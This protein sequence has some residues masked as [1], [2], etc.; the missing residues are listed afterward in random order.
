MRIFSIVHLRSK[1][2]VSPARRSKLGR[3]N[4]TAN[5]IGSFRLCGSRR[6]TSATATRSSLQ[7]RTALDAA[8][9]KMPVNTMGAGWGQQ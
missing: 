8:Y 3:G 6:L 9:A 4:D 7:A 1:R 5:Q 2:R